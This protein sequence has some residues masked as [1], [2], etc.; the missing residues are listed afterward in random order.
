MGAVFRPGSLGRIE[1]FNTN[2]LSHSTFM[3]NSANNG[4]T[5]GM[6]MGGPTNGMS[7]PANGMCNATNSTQ[8][9][10]MILIIVITGLFVWGVSDHSCM[11]CIGFL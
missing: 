6:S 8:K 2:G 7:V 3:Q 9:I 4:P 5:N 1:E 11:F 10:L